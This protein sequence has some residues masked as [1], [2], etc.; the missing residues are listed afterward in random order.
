MNIG[1]MI[2]VLVFH[3]LFA[4][5]EKK[6]QEIPE[7]IKLS[8]RYL[9][10]SLEYPGQLAQSVDFSPDSE[11]SKN[12]DYV[13]DYLIQFKT[14]FSNPSSLKKRSSSYAVFASLTGL[15]LSMGKDL[16]ESI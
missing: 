11:L 8:L 3:S 12:S 4:S 1:A 15:P 6:R 9:K 2:S 14:P 10:D 7:D 5:S 16:S 13:R